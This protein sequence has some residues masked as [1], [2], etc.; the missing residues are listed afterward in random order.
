M[1]KPDGKKIGH[2]GLEDYLSIISNEKDIEKAIP[3]IEKVHH[4]KFNEV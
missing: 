3:L 4:I 2:W 1:V